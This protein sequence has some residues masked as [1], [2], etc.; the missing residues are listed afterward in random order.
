MELGQYSMEIIATLFFVALIAGFIDTLAGGGG[1]ITL[2]ALILS[3]VPPIAAL[4]T[5]K[6]QGSMGTATATAILIK[7]KHFDFLS[8][9]PLLLFAFAGACLGAFS[10]QFIDTEALTFIIPLILVIICLYFL[11]APTPRSTKARLTDR[12]FKLFAVSPVGFYDGMFGPGTGSFFALAGVLGKGQDLIKASI[13]AKA[14]NFATNIASLLVF[15]VAGQ[16]LWLIG[17]VMMAG[18]FIGAWIGA[19]YLVK[20]NPKILKIII[21]TMCS[22]MLVKYFF[23]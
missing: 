23:F 21:V 3:G 9:W 7:G 8:Q 17:L 14:L 4:A 1:L 20:I 15:I 22:L 18:Q 11:F 2:P 10:V 5:N 16:V 13:N 12:Q 6:L 19:N